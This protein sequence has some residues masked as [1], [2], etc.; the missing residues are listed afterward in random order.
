M[1]KSHLTV[2]VYKLEFDPVL[3]TAWWLYFAGKH[4]VLQNRPLTYK[5][6]L[7]LDLQVA[8]TAAAGTSFF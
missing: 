6:S 5:M 4:S 3:G 8:K 2:S 7:L 1:K